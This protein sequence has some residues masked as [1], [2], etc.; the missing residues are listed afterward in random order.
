MTGLTQEHIKN[1]CDRFEEYVIPFNEEGV[2]MYNLPRFAE[3]AHGA[4]WLQPFLVDDD[5]DYLDHER[6]PEEKRVQL[7]QQRIIQRNR[8][9]EDPWN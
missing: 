2:E 7:D 3:Y 5:D 1:L 6:R 9:R 4:D 8:K